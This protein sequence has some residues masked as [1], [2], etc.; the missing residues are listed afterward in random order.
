MKISL[1]TPT[2]D[3]KYLN[4][5]YNSIVEQTYS[6]WEWILYIN[7]KGIHQKIPSIISNDPRVKVIVDK[8][9]NH[10]IGYLKNRAF[11]AGTGDILLEMDHDDLLVSTCLEKV[12]L[13]FS[14]NS[15]IGFV[16]SDDAKMQT[17]AEFKPFGKQFG[18]EDPYTFE[19]KG[20]SYPV[21]GG[22][23]SPFGL[24]YSIQTVIKK[25][26]VRESFLFIY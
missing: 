18:W 22:F 2:H 24:F 6:N 16:Y 7:G 15:D 12:A 26:L 21:M 25:T 14:E 17:N 3:F 9:N 8:S 19:Y 10:N 11:H 4:D 13:V 5:L 23:E 1:I 20:N